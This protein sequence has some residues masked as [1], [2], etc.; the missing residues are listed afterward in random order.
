MKAQKSEFIKIYLSF[1][2]YL[3]KIKY[4]FRIEA[5]IENAKRMKQAHTAFTA[6]TSNSSHGTSATF[7]S[8]NGFAE[9][10]NSGIANTLI[11]PQQPVPPQS[12][13]Q[14]LAKE[15]NN[16]L[17]GINR[18]TTDRTTATPNSNSSIPLNSSTSGTSSINFNQL[19]NFNQL[20]EVY[21]KNYFR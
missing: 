6:A 10:L 20:S 14:L 5:V 9:L 2:K 11:K 17:S 13:A 4:F 16:S 8:L 15:M 19:G 3:S 1:I 12:T 7:S 21:F 18:S